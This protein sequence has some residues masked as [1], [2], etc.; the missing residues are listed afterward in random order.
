MQRMFIN[1]KQPTSR[2]I[3]RAHIRHCHPVRHRQRRRP[4]PVE[5]NELAHAI[6]L[7]QELG[8][9]QHHVRGGDPWGQ[10]A[11]EVDPDDLGEHQAHGLA[12]HGG[13]GLDAS[14]APGHDAYAVYHRG[15]AVRPHAPIR[16]GDPVAHGDHLC[17]LLAVHLVH[18]ACSRRHHRTTT[19]A[20]LCPLQE[21]EPL[22]V[23]LK[24]DL[25]ILR[26]SIRGAGY[27][28]NH[29]VVNHKVH[30]AQR[31]H[32]LGVAASGFHRIPHR[33]EVNK[34]RDSRQILQ[35]NA[36]RK[37][38]EIRLPCCVLVVQDGLNIPLSHRNTVAVANGRLQKKPDAHRQGRHP[39]VPNLLQRH[40]SVSGSGQLVPTLAERREKPHPAGFR[41]L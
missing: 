37:P 23:P 41:A 2:P 12:E 15:V 8:H 30:P 38:V 22:L 7:A 9:R 17:D 34:N 21:L 10:A 33:A 1:R 32:S 27:I 14:H 26:Q 18:N 20:L 4:L 40:E 6:V 31:V 35:D 16:V 29:G 36:G 19:E 5:L 25:H 28:H 11:L 13:L 39:V 3:L 24:L